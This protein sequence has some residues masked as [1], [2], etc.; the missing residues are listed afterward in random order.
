MKEVTRYDE[1]GNPIVLLEPAYQAMDKTFFF[2]F[3]YGAQLEMDAALLED[4]QMIDELREQLNMA[5]ARI[6]VLEALTA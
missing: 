5:L 2:F 6:D 4:R 1:D 3:M